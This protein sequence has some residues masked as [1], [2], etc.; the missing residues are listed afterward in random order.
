MGM[1]VSADTAHTRRA[2][3]RRGV[4]GTAHA[5][6]AGLHL[7]SDSGFLVTRRARE[8][9]A[10]MADSAHSLIVTSLSPGAAEAVKPGECKS[11]KEKVGMA[12]PQR[13]RS[14]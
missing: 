7:V 2:M 8:G 12:D 11:R 4:Q 6:E 1:G 9:T 13:P 5:A 10:A 3:R 14:P